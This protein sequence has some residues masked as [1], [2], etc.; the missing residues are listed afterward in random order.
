MGSETGAA[1]PAAV[2]TRLGTGA[3]GT[4][5][6]GTMDARTGT[7]AEP[8]ADSEA[9]GAPVTGRDATGGIWGLG[10][11]T[12]GFTEGKPIMV[13][14]MAGRGAA[15][16]GAGGVAVGP[17]GCG[18]RTAGM[19]ADARAPGISDGRGEDCDGGGVGA[20][21]GRDPEGRVGDFAPQA[22]A[23]GAGGPPRSMVISP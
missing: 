15:G 13:R 10:A 22:G 6:V 4:E 2:G 17:A 12:G 21:A 18:V 1:G 14:P 5:G 11:A 9:V 3:E 20:T 8:G 16:A 7:G 23:V 19:V